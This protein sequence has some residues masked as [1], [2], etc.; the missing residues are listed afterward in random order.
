MP[1]INLSGMNPEELAAEADKAK[2]EQQAAIDAG[3]GEGFGIAAGTDVDEKRASDERENPSVVTK[4]PEKPGGL[5][6]R[7]RR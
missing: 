7:L 4:S 5:L 6:G 1:V 3:Q 2:K